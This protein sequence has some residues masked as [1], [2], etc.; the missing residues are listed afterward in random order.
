MI[1][2]YPFWRMT[3]QNPKAVYACMNLFKTYCPREIQKQAI[4]MEG[5][6]GAEL[7]KL[8]QIKNGKRRNS[9][10]I[11]LDQSDRYFFQIPRFLCRY[12]C[13]PYARIAHTVRQPIQSYK[14]LESLEIHGK[15]CYT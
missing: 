5:D 2:K 1:I 3:Y 8:C 15:V 4:C 6:I 12:G 10:S 14:R 7:K 13:N 11:S 9:I